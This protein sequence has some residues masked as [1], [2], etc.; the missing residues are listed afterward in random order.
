MTIYFFVKTLKGALRVDWVL[1]WY[2]IGN[3]K[4]Q[5]DAKQNLEKIYLTVAGKV[6]EIIKEKNK[7]GP[8]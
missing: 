7:K 8:T 3:G 2:Q 6:K 5:K 1:E 4:K